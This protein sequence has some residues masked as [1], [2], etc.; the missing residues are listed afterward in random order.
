MNIA[1]RGGAV[2]GLL[3]AG[4][5]AVCLPQE[6]AGDRIQELHQKAQLEEKGGHVDEAIQDYKK[7]LELDPKLAAAYSNLGRLYYQRGQLDEAIKPLQRASQIDPKLEPPRALLGFV[8]FQL[9]DFDK[10]RRELRVA[11]QLNPGD[12]TARLFL[13][14]SLVELHDFD[15]ALKLLTQLER[16]DPKNTEVL[17]TLGN[18]YS[19]LAEITIGKIQTVDPNSYLLELVLGKVAEIK[20]LYPDAVEHYKR[21]IA[22]AP[23]VPDLYY[24]YAHVLWAEGDSKTALAAYDRALEQNPVDYRALWESARILLAD[25][26]QEALRRSDRALALKPD[27]AGA[28][29]IRGR[30]LLAL[31]KPQDAI[32][33]LKKAGAIDPDDPTIHFQLARAYRQA[34]LPQEAQNENAIYERMDKE[35]HAAQEQKQPE[36]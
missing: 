3:T 34:G 1:V 25:N 27:V 19:S 5:V 24:K 7:I 18:L 36:P 16:T 2:I 30:A 9:E 11:A 10:A 32:E 20:Q 29:A 4:L 21:A 22:R 35:A 28:Q 6:G 26:P 33:A 17:Y 15:G 8:F 12:S 13:A 23:D 31:D 14:R